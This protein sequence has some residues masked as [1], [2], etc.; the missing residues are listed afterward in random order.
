MISMLVTEASQVAEARRRATSVARALGFGETA[1]GRVALVATELATNLVKY[2]TNGE[3]LIG[4]YERGDETGVEIMA[5]DR[6]EGLAD[7]QKALSDGHST[8]GSAGIGLG[9]I[10]R[11]SRTFDI[12][13]SPGRGVAVLSRVCPSETKVL[14]ADPRHPDFGVA[15]VPLRGEVANGDAYCLR[16]N[17]GGWTLI[18]ADG[19]GHGPDAARASSE[20][21]RVFRDHEDE[22]PTA[23]LAAVHAGLRSTRGGAV[24]VAR[25]DVGKALLTFCGVGNVAGTIVEGGRSRGTVVLAGTAGHNARRLQAFEYPLAPG[26]LFVLCS[27]GIGSGWNLGDYPGLTAAHP[28]L[29]AAIL[30]RDHARARDDATVAVVRAGT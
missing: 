15:T 5:L 7:A 10:R 13:S 12:F 14:P 20:A 8:G 3:I 17:G 4:S 21:V 26:G 11:L 22:Q 18:V 2:A 16:P 23:I 19:L 6:G 28:A 1:T 29:M 24:S 30:Y 27:D 25:Y 9:A